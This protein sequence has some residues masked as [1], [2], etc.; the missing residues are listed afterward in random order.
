MARDCFPWFRKDKNCWYV[1]RDGKQVRLHK[2]KAE[3]FRIWHTLE[4]GLVPASPEPPPAVVTVGQAVDAYL[5]E[6]G[7]RCKPSTMQSKRKVLLRLKAHLG[8]MDAS[9]LTVEAFMNWLNRQS[10]G[11]STRWLAALVIKAAFRRLSPALAELSLPAP[12]SRGSDSLIN[13]ADHERLLAAAPLSYRNA[14]LTLWATGCRPCEL[15]SV[16][17]RHLDV[18]ATAFVLDQHKTDKTGRP[19]IIL[20]PAAIF[21]LCLQL[22]E[23]HPSGPLFRNCKGQPLSPDRLRNWLFKTRRRLGLG[24]LTPYGYRHSFA[25]DALANGVPDAHVA[26]ML[27]HN[28]TAMLHKH[29]SHLGARCQTLREAL[30]KV[31]AG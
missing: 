31:R 30:G 24:R 27:G 17:A 2:E 12:F 5:V 14:L 16:E 9:T 23:R 22:A 20:L 7:T 19:R 21:D 15:C 8:Q 6:A 1:W 26:A 13:P 29:Y 4:A 11:R 25:T 28:G 3:A 10:W 18:S